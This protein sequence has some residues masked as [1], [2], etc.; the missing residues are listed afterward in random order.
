MSPNIPQLPPPYVLDA[1][2]D[3]RDANGKDELDAAFALH[4]DSM[5]STHK[6]RI[7][8]M[9]EYFDRMEVVYP[10]FFDGMER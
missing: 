2:H 7:T 3:I 8:L 1:V 10:Q 9:G 4:K 6:D 5:G